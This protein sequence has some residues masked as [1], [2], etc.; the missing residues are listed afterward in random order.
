MSDEQALP[1]GAE[2]RADVAAVQWHMQRNGYGVE[3]RADGEWTRQWANEFA[4]ALV[5]VQR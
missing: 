5:E 4:R 1:P 2:T 3:L